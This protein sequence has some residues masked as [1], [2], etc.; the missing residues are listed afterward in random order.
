MVGKPFT[1]QMRRNISTHRLEDRV[2][3]LNTVSNE[4]LRTLYCA[5]QLLLFPSWEEGFGWPIIEAQACGCR[6]VIADR[7]P[8]TEIGGDAAA[9]LKL[10]R[11]IE[12][13]PD[14]A[15]LSIRAADNAANSVMEILQE[16]GAE[17]MERVQKGLRNAAR[18]TTGR[19]VESYV[20]LYRQMRSAGAEPH[21]RASEPISVR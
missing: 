9:Y 21:P 3:E 19:M 13:G 5:A 10:E 2:I 14:D 16:T 1:P 4:D 12:P 6:V 7:E 15:S 17:R 11:P 18:F 8:M 20:D